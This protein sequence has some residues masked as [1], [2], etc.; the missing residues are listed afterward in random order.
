MD[1]EERILARLSGNTFEDRLWAATFVGGIEREKLAAIQA[2]LRLLQEDQVVPIG[3]P[4]DYRYE[5]CIGRAA[6]SLARLIKRTELPQ[7]SPIVM[8][9][10]NIL[11]KLVA[12]RS[13]E[14]MHSARQGLVELDRLSDSERN[15][16]SGESEAGK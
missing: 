15:G 11:L 1:Y 14:I 10:R 3:I 2:L 8:E 13:V 6:V 9:S 7:D 5:L 4:T 12:Q 16:G